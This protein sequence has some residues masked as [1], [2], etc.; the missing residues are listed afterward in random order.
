MNRKDRIT[1]LIVTGNISTARADLESCLHL[2]N[3][4]DPSTIQDRIKNALK[5]I[6]SADK[7]I[8]SLI[9]KKPAES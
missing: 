5:F 3:S 7:K 4:L 6:D 9:L 1:L 2:P 8:E